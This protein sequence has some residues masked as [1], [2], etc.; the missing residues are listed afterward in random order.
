MATDGVQEG[1]GGEELA[2]PQ[3]AVQE[4]HLEAS[5]LF[6]K[7]DCRSEAEASGRRGREQGQGRE[8]EEGSGVKENIDRV[9]CWHW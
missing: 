8:K 7:P 3:G 1:G 6:W 2:V 9:H 5:R 4:E